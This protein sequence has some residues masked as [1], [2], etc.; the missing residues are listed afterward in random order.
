MKD[1]PSKGVAGFFFSFFEQVWFLRKFSLLRISGTSHNPK[2]SQW[3][4]IFLSISWWWKLKCG[5]LTSG[6]LSLSCDFVLRQ[7]QSCLEVNHC[8]GFVPNPCAIMSA[9]QPVVASKINS[10]WGS[11]ALCSALYLEGKGFCS[12]GNRTLWESSFHVRVHTESTHRKVLDRTIH[13]F[14]FPAHTP[15]VH[16][17]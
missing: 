7:S 17:G 3:L 6:S 12:P 8:C 2:S 11:S 9:R 15:A 13:H 10:L 16:R 5:V 4:S 14:L 1:D